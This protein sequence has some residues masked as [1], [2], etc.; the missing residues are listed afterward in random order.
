MAGTASS[1]DFPASDLIVTEP[2][3]KG[4][5]RFNAG[6]Y[7]F[8]IEHPSGRQLLYDLGC[9]KDWENLSPATGVQRYLGA[10]VMRELTVERNVSEILTEGGVDLNDIEGVIWSH[11]HFDHIG[12]VSTF[13]GSTKLIVGEGTKANFMPGYP[14][15]A[16]AHTLDSDFE[17]RE[18]L[19]I[20]FCS[21]GLTIGGFRAFDYFRDGSF[22]I[23][24]SPGHSVGYLN[25]LARTHASPSA[26][27]IHMCGDTVHH[28][29]EIRPSQFLPLP[30]TIEQS[31]VPQVHPEAC[32][33]HFFQQILRDGST[34]KHVLESVDYIAGQDVERKYAGIYDM[35]ALKDSIEK[36][37]QL[38]SS[39]VVFTVMAHDWSLKGVIDEWPKSLNAWIER[40]WK[41]SSRWHFLKDFAGACA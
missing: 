38:D 39:K 1:L 31:P 26:G 11:L 28:A 24:N 33:G 37:E 40:H 15:D 17:G 14:T 30:D 32:P 41:E 3:I 34:E 22:Y 21:T 18:V 29:G 8:F 13:P 25:P 23:L 36:T 2:T 12:D 35:P 19:G 6:T 4:F 9:R 5:D 20:D 27:F 7:C 10:G 16:L